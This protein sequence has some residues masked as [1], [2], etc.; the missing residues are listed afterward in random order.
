MTTIRKASNSCTDLFAYN[1]QKSAVF[2]DIRLR[3]NYFFFK[4]LIDKGVS[5]FIVLFILSWLLPIIAIAIKMT[6]RGPVFFVQRRVGRYGK[7]FKCLKFRTMRMNIE[8]DFKQADENDGRITSVGLFLRRSNL[9]E[10]PQFLNVLLG[11]MSIVGP[12]PH[13]H[14]DCQNFTKVV[15]EYKV[16]NLVKP[17]ITGMAQI[18]GFRGPTNTTSSIVMRYNWDAYYVRNAGSALDIKVIIVTAQQTI[19]QIIKLLLTEQRLLMIKGL[20]ENYRLKKMAA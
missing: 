14:K 18:R 8:A 7:T 6:S 13:M 9:D 10:L 4:N 16:R 11:H 17:G 1:E 5:L 12:R 19:F 2:L 20:R 15:K 3:K